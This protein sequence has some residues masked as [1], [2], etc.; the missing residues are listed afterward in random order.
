MRQDQARVPHDGGVTG[1]GDATSNASGNRLAP[2]QVKR[3]W[4]AMRDRHDQKSWPIGSKVS[5]SQWYRMQRGETKTN[6]T[7]LAG[8]DTLMEWEEGSAYDVA[9]HGLPPRPLER[10]ALFTIDL[11]DTPPASVDDLRGAAN[12]LIIESDRM[13]SAER[14]QAVELIRQLLERSRARR[15]HKS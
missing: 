11:R 14:G 13:A 7:S 6:L 2:E 4:V 15:A 9:V 12:D 5:S 1:E 8:Y 3:L 10:S